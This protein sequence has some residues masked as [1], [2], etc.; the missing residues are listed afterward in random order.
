[1]PPIDNPSGTDD[2]SPLTLSEAAAAYADLSKVEEP[3]DSG[4]AEAE[5]DEQGLEADDTSELDDE[6]GETDDEGQA[7]DEPEL[8]ESPQYVADDAKVKLADGTEITVAELKNGTL[9]L[10]DYRRKTEELATERKAFAEK[11]QSFQQL[12]QQMTGDREF[13]VA[14]LQSIMPQK[15]DP[16][17][18]AVDPLGYGEQK[19]YYDAR[20]EQFDYLIS[21]TQQADARKQADETERLNTLRSAEW[22]ATLEKMPELKDGTRL[23]SFVREIQ[24][25]GAAYEFTPQEIAQVGLDHRQVLV[26]RDAI[27]WRKLQASKS[28]AAAKVEGRPPVQ[29]GG[30]RP[31]PQM[32]AARD[33]R[34]AMDR[35][36]QTGSI[37]DGVAALLALE[38]G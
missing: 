35:L 18:F 23:N 10:Q 4:H 27:A 38:K 32:Q 15:P 33:S 2:T 1:M 5:Q 29:R 7:E 11:S 14:L 31:T 36:R 25:H 28:K 17:M 20:K 24:Q 26:L 19:A 3:A 8:P 21:Q 37:K 13:M 6:T 16:S 22:E 9:R 12:E 34:A 30:T